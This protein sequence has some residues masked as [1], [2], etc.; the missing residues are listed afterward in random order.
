M[1]KLAETIAVDHNACTMNLT[2]SHKRTSSLTG[3][4]KSWVSGLFKIFDVR[5]PHKWASGIEGKEELAVNQWSQVLAG[6]DENQIQRGLKEWT[7]DWPPSAEEF[8]KACLGTGINQHG[9]N[10][11]PQHLREPN[12]ITDRA[13]V[14]SSDAREAERQQFR[15]N[16]HA[17]ANMVRGKES[18]HTAERRNRYIPNP[19]RL[20]AM[21]MGMLASMRAADPSKS[22]KDRLIELKRLEA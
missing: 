3:L 7:G 4:P 14:L 11:V 5:Y 9:E 19:A 10:Y 8:R 15:D 12:R 18:L 17:V 16:L 1:K 2:E 21:L 22:V 13:R 6:L 20:D